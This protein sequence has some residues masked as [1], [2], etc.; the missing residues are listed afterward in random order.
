VGRRGGQ[1]APRLRICVRPLHPPS[2][3]HPRLAREPEH[4]QRPFV[5]WVD[6]QSVEGMLFD[7]SSHLQPL[8]CWNG[9]VESGGFWH[10]LYGQK[11]DTLVEMDT[12]STRT[13]TLLHDGRYYQKMKGGGPTRISAFIFSSPKTTAALENPDAPFPISAAFRRNLFMLPWFNIS[14]SIAN[15]SEGLVARTIEVQR[16]LITGVID[17]L[18]S[19]FRHDRAG[20]KF[21][22][23][24]N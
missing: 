16:R 11:G 17:T 9:N 18:Q 1:P 22:A 4:D 5:L 3:P 23:G 10:G 20:W 13:N 8:I 24:P 2:L 15:W 14:S 6:L 19:E 21:R 12:R 7:Y